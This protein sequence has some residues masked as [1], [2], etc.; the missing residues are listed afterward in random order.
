[1]QYPSATELRAH[2]KA[3]ALWRQSELTDLTA[4]MDVRQPFESELEFLRHTARDEHDLP[5]DLQCE[6]FKL[7]RVWVCSPLSLRSPCE[8]KIPQ[9]GFQPATPDKQ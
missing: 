4:R 3:V 7:G 2:A 8:Q 1:M 6:E 9:K 5:F